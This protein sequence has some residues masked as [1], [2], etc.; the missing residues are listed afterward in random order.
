[1]QPYTF[2]NPQWSLFS[3]DKYD[4]ECPP[5]I[6]APNPANAASAKIYNQLESN[7]YF[8]RVRGVLPPV[9]FSPILV[10]ELN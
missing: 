5:A 9:A 10:L 6:T 7:Q 3:T 2:L 1:M 4:A 8:P